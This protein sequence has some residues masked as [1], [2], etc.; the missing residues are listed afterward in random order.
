MVDSVTEA[1]SHDEGRGGRSVTGVQWSV[2]GV[3]NKSV[4]G[5]L[6]ETSGHNHRRVTGAWLHGSLD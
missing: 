5:S 2:P 4:T 6:K 3:Q 1:K